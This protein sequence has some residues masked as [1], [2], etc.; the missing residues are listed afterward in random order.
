[1]EK[2]TVVSFL[3]GAVLGGAT[4]FF[5]ESYLPDRITWRRNLRVEQKKWLAQHRGPAVRAI[6]ELQQRIYVM[7]FLKPLRLEELNSEDVEYQKESLAFLVAQCC[8]RLEMLRGKMESL[9]YDKLIKKLDP[10]SRT[11]A[12][13]GRDFQLHRLHQQEIA[14]LMVSG[15]AKDEPYSIGYSKFLATL[16]TQETVRC[17]ARLRRWVDSIL[18]RWPV[19]VVMLV[20]IQNALVDALDFLDKRCQWIPVEKRQRLEGSAVIVELKKLRIIDEEQAQKL[21]KQLEEELEKQPA[22]RK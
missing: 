20:T 21:E 2:T 7:V 16:K 18:E 11:L 1:M 22:Q 6:H 12:G 13:Y 14:E 4:K 19:E 15:D 3:L 17:W 8:A 9:D 10:I 5:W